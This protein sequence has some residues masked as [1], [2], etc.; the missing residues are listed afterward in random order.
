[1]VSTDPGD[2]L[3]WL[4]HWLIIYLYLFFFALKRHQSSQWCSCLLEYLLPQA[5]AS[6]PRHLSIYQ[7]APRKHPKQTA[8]ISLTLVRWWSLMP[9][10]CIVVNHAI[11]MFV[12]TFGHLKKIQSMSLAAR[13]LLTYVHQRNQW[14][15]VYK[16]SKERICFSRF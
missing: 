13:K 11:T 8:Q 2:H 12:S 7:L 5:A 10:Y 9:L 1:M 15:I 3:S 14:P 16:I 6:R 4:R